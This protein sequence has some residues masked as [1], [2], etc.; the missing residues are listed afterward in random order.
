MG[1][2]LYWQDSLKTNEV[3][4]QPCSGINALVSS[5]VRKLQVENVIYGFAFLS[6]NLNFLGWFE[7]NFV[8]NLLLLATRIWAFNSL[9]TIQKV[10][11]SNNQFCVLESSN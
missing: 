6:N 9:A 7:S 8:K 1:L 11:W 3:L 10:L 5:F 2:I 4:I